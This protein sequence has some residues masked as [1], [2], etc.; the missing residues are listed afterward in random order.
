MSQ[1]ILPFQ[2]NYARHPG[3]APH[4]TWD[5]RHDAGAD[6]AIDLLNRLLLECESALTLKKTTLPAALEQVNE[7]VRLLM[8]LLVSAH[9]ATG[10]P[11][12]RFVDR[13]YLEIIRI[14]IDDLAYYERRG[15]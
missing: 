15:S 14:V 13:F 6:E 11:F 5:S 7:G 2:V 9:N 4:L 10:A 8:Q 1:S 12:A 3:F